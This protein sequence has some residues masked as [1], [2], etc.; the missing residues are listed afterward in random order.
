MRS[1]RVQAPRVPDAPLRADVIE[2]RE[3]VRAWAAQKARIVADIS[4]LQRETATKVACR[5]D[6]ICT[7]VLQDKLEGSA[8]W[9]LV[10][11][12]GVV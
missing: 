4:I 11:C 6:V 12:L 1:P 10:K 7:F 8:P 5:I 3:Q 9:L 2:H